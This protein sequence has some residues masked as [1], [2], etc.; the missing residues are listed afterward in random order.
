MDSLT[1][2]TND[3]LIAGDLDGGYKGGRGAVNITKKQYM[4]K[5]GYSKVL[6]MS[7]K[8]TIASKMT[9]QLTASM[10]RSLCRS[11]RGKSGVYACFHIQFA[12]YA[13]GVC[14]IRQIIRK[15]MR[16]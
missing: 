5:N 4:E 1:R 16:M 12:I 6:K 9:Q 7:V 2:E 15:K 14:H 11:K 13:T 3:D 10:M 8:P